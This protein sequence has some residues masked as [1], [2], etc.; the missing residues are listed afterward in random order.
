MQTKKKWRI[1]FILRWN[2]LIK[3]QMKIQ[4]LL[5]QLENLKELNLLFPDMVQKKISNIIFQDE[6]EIRQIQSA[7][8][9][10]S[11]LY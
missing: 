8:T 11:Q 3:L 9:C 5:D 10:Q 7:S 1:P 6:N 4:V 2:I